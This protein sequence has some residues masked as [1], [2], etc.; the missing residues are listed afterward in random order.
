[1]NLPELPKQN[2]K[3]E[4]EFGIKFRRFIEEHPPHFS[5]GYE[6]K[7]TR[8]KI[9]LNFNEVSDEQIVNA[10]KSKSDKG[11]LIRLTKATIGSPDYEYHKNFPR[12]IVI[13]YPRE[14]VMIDIE[15]FIMEKKR[16][17]RKSL[18]LKRAKE[19]S[20]I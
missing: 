3:K 5:C 14:F 7:D 15:T 1:M 18:L 8:G 12:Y 4:A 17:K 19:L 20:I 11:H 9:Y 13:K 2:K 16:S 6:L 10:L